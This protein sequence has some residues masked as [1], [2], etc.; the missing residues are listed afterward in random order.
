M[1]GDIDNLAHLLAGVARRNRY[2]NDF[3]LYGLKRALVEVLAWFPIY[4]T[5]ITEITCSEADQQV[6]SNTARHAADAMPDFEREI[7]FIRDILLLKF[8]ENITDSHKKQWIQF[9]I[10][11]QQMSGPLMAK[12]YEDTVFYLYNRFISLNEVG[13]NPD[14]FG[15]SDIQFH[16]FNKVRV[17]KWPHGLNTTSTHDTKRGEDVRARLNVLSQIPHDWQRHV[18]MWTKINLNKKKRINRVPVPD[19]NDEY[20][21]YQTLIGTWPFFKHEQP[22][23]NERI[24]TF[25][26]KATRE[27]KVHTAWLKPDLD[28]ENAYLKFVDRLFDFDIFL[29]EF[30][31]FQRKIAFYGVVN[32]LSQLVLKTTLPGVPDFYQGTELWDLTLVDPDNRRAVDY[33]MRTDSLNDIKRQEQS[34]RPRLIQNLLSN[35]AD[36]KI[37]LFLMDALLSLRTKY[38]DFFNHGSYTP[39]ETSGT[40]KDHIIAYGRQFKKKWIICIVPRNVT[41]ADYNRFPLGNDIWKDTS[42]HLPENGKYFDFL[43]KKRFSATNNIKAGEAFF[44]FPQAVFVSL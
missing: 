5:Y 42:V 8:D 16:Y 14:K 17:S 41:F 44:Q 33:E 28:Y 3:T 26:I 23:F 31:P 13:G 15:V 27:A 36:G 25:I 11:F 29:D 24:K 37:K 43:S 20:F 21:L 2:G 7:E 40:Y 34:D 19:K 39:L 18:M 10:R 35:Y 4:R 22:E 12:G 1:A 32:S 38:A 6:V 30:I 9:V